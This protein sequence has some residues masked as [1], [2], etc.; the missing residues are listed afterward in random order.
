[1]KPPP[2]NYVAVHSTEEAIETLMR[3]GGEAKLLAGGQSLMPML[4]FRLLA[5]AVLVD[6]NPIVNLDAVVMTDDG[7]SVG[8]LTRHRT[9]ETAA[10]V[11]NHFPILSSAMSDVAHLAIRNRGTIGGSL[12]HA[13]PAAELPMLSLLLDATIEASGP[14]GTRHISAADFFIAPLE[15]ALG[16]SE[17]ITTIRLP[18]L[19]QHRWGFAE[20]SRRAGDF[21]LVAAATVFRLVDGKVEDP[22]IALIGAG[23]IPLRATAAEQLLRGQRPTP[24]TLETAAATTARDLEPPS[25]LHASADYRRHLVRVLTRRVLDQAMAPSPAIVE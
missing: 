1:M 12:S 4:N 10:L 21:A 9:L 23:E 24:A 7:L 3:H 8:A 22:R 15:T 25:D 13:D 6:I 2:F 14:G 19:H 5:P 16:E 11:S 20:V 17:M 18:S